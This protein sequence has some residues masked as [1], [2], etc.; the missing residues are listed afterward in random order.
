MLFQDPEKAAQYGSNGARAVR[1][2]WNWEVT[3][4]DLLTLYSRFESV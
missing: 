3:S 4:K 2:R 1:E